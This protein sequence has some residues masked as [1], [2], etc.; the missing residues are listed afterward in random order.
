MK[1][2]IILVI[3]GIIIGIG[4]IMPGVSGGMLAISLN[5][6]DKSIE[7]ISNFFKDIKSNLSFLSK[8]GLGIIIAIILFSKLINYALTYYY[9][10]T[11]L[12]FIGLIIGGIP[13]ILK[14]IKN[15][16]RIKNINLML[17]PMII[18]LGM[19][20]FN[21]YLELNQ[22][23]NS[24][25]ITLFILGIIEAISM[26]IPG[27]S[28][29]AIFMMI[30]YYNLIIETLNNLTVP[31][32]FMG[33]IIKI[34]PFIIGMIIGIIGLV[35]IINYLLRK[36]RIKCFYII[37]GFTLSSIFILI[38]NVIQNNFSLGEWLVNLVFLG[39]CFIIG[40]YFE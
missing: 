3:K 11:M 21:N 5:V 23:S 4:K 14:E 27:I 22:V 30:G 6:Y 24:N 35:K 19:G 1:E 12:L 31:T 17:I 15:D 26:I 25:F 7:A 33:S 39:I 13:S 10:S 28:G 2:T 9:L 34:I 16:I 38:V 32:L 8:L 18:I 37:L 36:Y 40:R 29:T 20:I